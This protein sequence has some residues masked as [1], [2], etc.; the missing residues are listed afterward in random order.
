MGLNLAGTQLRP[1]FLTES[2][3]SNVT[4]VTSH[5]FLDPFFCG[6]CPQILVAAGP[7]SLT[8][9]VLILFVFFG[10]SYHHDNSRD[11]FVKGRKTV[12]LFSKFISNILK[13][14]GCS[15][16]GALPEIIA[17]YSQTLDPGD[18][19]SS[20]FCFVLFCWVDN[21]NGYYTVQSPTTN[22]RETL[23]FKRWVY[24]GMFAWVPFIFLEASDVRLPCCFNFLD[25]C[26]TD[27]TGS[28]T[29]VG[30]PR[31]NFLISFPRLLGIW[32]Q[33]ISSFFIHKA[34][35]LQGG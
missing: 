13:E 26:T 32:G 7:L 11:N 10:Q 2:R 9:K 14:E 4:G 6:R 23:K 27:T 18:N 30:L 5:Q 24:V 15:N 12:K 20:T 33:L 34:W 28:Y 16:I 29:T 3:Y 8:M 17:E 25:H 19:C 21:S 35:V 1:E 22:L 31:C